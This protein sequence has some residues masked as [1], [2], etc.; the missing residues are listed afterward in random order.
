MES[1]QV[2][3]ELLH[4]KKAKQEEDR[5]QVNVTPKMSQEPHIIKVPVRKTK[6]AQMQLEE[7][8]FTGF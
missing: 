2:T 5:S 6:L 7:A 4:E 8:K 3:A 1:R